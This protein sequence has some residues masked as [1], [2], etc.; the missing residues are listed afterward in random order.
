MVWTGIVRRG[1]QR[2]Q[3]QMCCALVAF[4]NVWYRLCRSF[5]TRVLHRQLPTRIL[6]ALAEPVRLCPLRA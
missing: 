4:A 6:L 3:L 1:F 5:G 2:W